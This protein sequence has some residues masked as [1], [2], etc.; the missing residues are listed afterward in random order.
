MLTNGKAARTTATE[1]VKAAPG[2][3]QSKVRLHGYTKAK[4]KAKEAGTSLGEET[5]AMPETTEIA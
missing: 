2:M 1:R 3:P 4:A 5:Q